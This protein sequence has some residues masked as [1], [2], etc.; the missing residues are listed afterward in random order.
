LDLSQDKVWLIYTTRSAGDG[1][2]RYVKY[3]F[4]TGKWIETPLPDGLID[5]HPTN[6]FMAGSPE[7]VREGVTIFLPEKKNQLR[8]VPNPA[9]YE[10]QVGPQQIVP[11]HKGLTCVWDPV[12]QTFNATRID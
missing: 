3:Q 4:Q 5:V 10:K 12:Y 7:D 9:Y 6:L 11:V 8:S 1:C 2:V